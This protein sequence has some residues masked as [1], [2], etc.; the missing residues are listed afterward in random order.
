[1]SLSA[2]SVAPPLA[3]SRPPPL[4]LQARGPGLSVD[5]GDVHDGE[6]AIVR[7]DRQGLQLRCQPE[8]VS[9][10]YPHWS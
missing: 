4:S 10:P 8:Q 7:R 9:V 3:S 5:P 6:R 1:V 2:S